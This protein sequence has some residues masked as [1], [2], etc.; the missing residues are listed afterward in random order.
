MAIW[1]WVLEAYGQPGVQ[2]QFFFAQKRFVVVHVG[3]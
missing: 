3:P 1:D 2:R